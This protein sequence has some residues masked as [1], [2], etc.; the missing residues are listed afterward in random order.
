MMMRGPETAAQAAP[1]SA[2]ALAVRTEGLAKSYGALQ[3]TN[4]VSLEI[5]TGELHAIIGPNGAGKTTLINLLCGEQQLDAG[6]IWVGND[7]MTAKPVH[8]RVQAGMLR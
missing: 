2:P 8:A 1:R 4:G 7:D 5:E 3:V 6:R